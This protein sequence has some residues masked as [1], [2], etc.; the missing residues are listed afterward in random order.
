MW[1]K[2]HDTLLDHRKL[3]RTCRIL[4]IDGVSLRGH[5]VTLWLNVLRH[6]PDGDLD[7][8]SEDDIE[9][10]AEWAGKPGIFV[11]SLIETA[12][13]DIVD[14]RAVIHDWAEHS[15][16]LHVAR[17]RKQNRERQRKHRENKVVSPVSNALVTRD[18]T[19]DNARE[20][21]RG[22]EKRGG[23]KR[24]DNPVVLGVFEHYRKY[25]PRAHKK[26]SS[27]MQEWKK[28]LTRLGEGYSA[29][30]L[31]LAIDGCHVSP[32]HMGENE[33]G[34]KFDSLELIVRDSSKVNQFIEVVNQGSVTKTATKKSI[35]A[36]EQWLDRKRDE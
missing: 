7:D 20:E 9:H 3:R 12:W 5:L 1:L 36:T 18:V 15:E 22:E 26:P 13:I 35:R 4:Q 8:W 33:G 24:G 21:R 17:V 10:Y 31:C 28:I 32:Y 16:N 11:S 2:V 34:R 23:E 27:K 25:H 30:D 29:E 6:S 14:D 19:L